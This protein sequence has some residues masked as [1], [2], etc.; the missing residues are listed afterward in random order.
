[1]DDYFDSVQTQLSALCAQR[2]HRRLV[3]QRPPKRGASIAMLVASAVITAAVFVLALGVVSG[4]NHPVSHPPGG[5]RP[6]PV[7]TGP[8]LLRGIPQRGR[9]LGNPRAPVKIALVADLES[10]IS[11]RFT[12]GADFRKLLAK[13]VRSGRVKLYF[14]SLCTATGALPGGIKRCRNERSTFY[15]QQAAAYAAGEQNR[16]WDYVL[17]FF[18][19]QGKEGTPYVTVAF[20]KRLADHIRGLN[21]RRWQADRKNPRTLAQVHADAA[22]ARAHHLTGTPTLVV[23]GPKGRV[24][25]QAL[26]NSYRQLADAIAKAQSHRR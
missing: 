14:R 15:I 16:L 24:L 2:A 18:K 26:P 11:R 21:L 13:N 5:R 17:L 6:T 3:R 22:Y 12:D 9:L 19:K 23:T 25:I 8:R 7:P 4:G 1:M 10:V 20:L